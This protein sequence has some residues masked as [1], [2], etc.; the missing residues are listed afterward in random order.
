[1]QIVVFTISVILCLIKPIRFC[2]IKEILIVIQ[3]QVHYI[4]I[5]YALTTHMLQCAYTISITPIH[6]HR[7]ITIAYAQTQAQTHTYRQT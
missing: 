5:V 1:M 3:T 7:Q 4:I 2:D 6:A